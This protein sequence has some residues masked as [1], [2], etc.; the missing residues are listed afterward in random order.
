[1]LVWLAVAG[2]QEVSQPASVVFSDSIDVFSFAAVDSGWQP[3]ASSALAVRFQVVPTGGVVT[4]MEAVSELTWTESAFQH[5]LVPV[6]G[7]GLFG[8]DTAIDIDFDVK[9]D[10]SVWDGTLDVWNAG[11]SIVEIATFDSLLLDGG[12]PS[13]MEITV[14]DVG[15]WQP[16]STTI[17]IIP[18]VNLEVAVDVIP[19]LTSIFSGSHIDTQLLDGSGSMDG[20]GT[21]LELDLPTEPM[22]SVDLT[23]TY[24]GQLYNLFAVVCRPSLT[25]DSPIGDWELAAF[26]IPFDLLDLASDR[27]FEAVTYAHPLPAVSEVV[28]PPVDDVLVGTQINVEIP[29]QNMGDLVLEGTA[30]VEGGDAFSV[31]P[32]YFAATTDQTAGV[33]VTFAPSEEGDHQAF[34]VLETNDPTLQFLRIPLNGTA[35]GPDEVPD[36]NIDD[37]DESGVRAR[38]DGKACGC[39]TSRPPFG[40]LALGLALPLLRRRR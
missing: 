30:R 34:L 39:Q 16:F 18:T 6:V 15:V 2:A 25:L 29:L 1:M 22:A 10:V 33:V 28:V 13:E 8:V 38:T 7:A 9:I 19:E 20:E 14:D 21:F 35:F 37:P 26:D 11:F 31:W 40:L 24:H 23:S 32:P 36:P 17:G 27:T 4:E 5:T 3:S 12:A